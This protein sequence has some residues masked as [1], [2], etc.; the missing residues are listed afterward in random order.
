MTSVG[1]QERTV[2]GGYTPGTRGFDALRVGTQEGRKLL[3]VAKV[4]AGFTPPSRDAVFKRLSGLETERCPFANLPETHRGRW[5][6]GLTAEEMAECRWLKP[7]LIA[8][9]EF[10]EETAANHLLH[11]KFVRLPQQH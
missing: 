6:E 11:A 9:I 3:Y 4:R 7:R 2:I 1:R 8:M 5:G 10:L